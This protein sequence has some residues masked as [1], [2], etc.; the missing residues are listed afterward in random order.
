[1]N[2]YILYSWCFENKLFFFHKLLRDFFSIFFYPVTLPPT[3]PPPLTQDATLVRCVN[4]Q[5]IFADKR[6][7]WVT[8]VGDTLK[9]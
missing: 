8:G 6:A 3:L 1:M 4:V 2:I 7:C 9:N 5:E